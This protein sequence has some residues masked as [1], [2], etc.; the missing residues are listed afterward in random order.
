MTSTEA[1]ADEL[2]QV[3]DVT[4]TL[5]LA[6]EAVR[7]AQEARNAVARD[8]VRGGFTLRD[9][10]ALLGLTHTAVAKVTREDWGPYRPQTAADRLQAAREAFDAAKRAQ[11]LREERYAMGYRQETRTFYGERDTPVCDEQEQR[12]RWAGF[13][14]P[15]GA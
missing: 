10:G 12:V 14:Q 13:H 5:R 6:Q 4:T 2:A 3:E 8:L 15:A 11:K 7:A 9:T 1:L